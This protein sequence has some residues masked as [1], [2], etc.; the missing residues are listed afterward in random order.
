[1]V[2]E[3]HLLV[4]MGRGSFGSQC[5]QVLLNRGSAVDKSHKLFTVRC[6]QVL[7]VMLISPNNPGLLVVLPWLSDMPLWSRWGA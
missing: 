2:P 6:V 5:A 4:S 3:C 1:M 7:V